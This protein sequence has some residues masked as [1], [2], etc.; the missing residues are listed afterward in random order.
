MTY[1]QTTDLH[2]IIDRIYD[3]A[4]S[5]EKWV[6]L[7][8]ALGEHI[9]IQQFESHIQYKPSTLVITDK[10]TNTE[11]QHF[12]QAQDSDLT[13]RQTLL[14]TSDL[15]EINL[16]LGKHFMRALKITQSLVNSEQQ[17]ELIVNFLDKLP[18]AV[19]I[20]D[21]QL[22]VFQS[23]VHA[24]AYIHETSV[25]KFQNNQLSLRSSRDQEKLCKLTEALSNVETSLINQLPLVADDPESEDKQIIIIGTPIKI[26]SLAS[27]HMVALFVSNRSSHPLP[28]PEVLSELYKLSDKE[29]EI[30]RLL[31]QGYSINEISELTTVSKHTVRNQ[32]KSIFSKTDTSRQ[33]ELVSLVLTGPG[34][35]TYDNRTSIGNIQSLNTLA[36]AGSL[37]KFQI[38]NRRTISWQE[39]GDPYG[40]AVIYGHS[41][42]GSSY[43]ISFD[44]DKILKQKGIRLIAPDRPGRCYS[45]A[46]DD[47][48]LSSLSHDLDKLLDH[49]KISECQYLGFE[50]GALF[51]AA[52][53]ALNKNRLKTLVLVSTGIIPDS[54]QEWKQMSSFFRMN[55][56]CAIHFPKVH[57]LF[58]NMMVHGIKEN[59]QRFLKTLAKQFSESEKSFTFPEQYIHGLSAAITNT[60]A[61]AAM[62][63]IEC[64]MPPGPWDF[65]MSEIECNIEQW[66]GVEDSFVP[67]ISAQ[68]LA[69][70]CPDQAQQHFIEG[71]GRF[72]FYTQFEK[73]IDSLLAYNH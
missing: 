40:Q 34:S 7:L 21:Q 43:E 16:V 10:E 6:D 55:L 73:I 68:R 12:L 44:Q 57:R 62:L 32:V 22:N 4:I 31:L 72:I 42:L 52:Y 46:D 18:V 8:H 65:E 48:S 13:S 41:S 26:A 17:N 15:N 59:P 71:E 39:Y 3:A 60:S 19:F 38:D 5:P 11:R 28:T 54:T 47:M 35:L 23:N 29:A 37:F 56:K 67:V 1:T 58:T 66:H 53:S 2:E 24:S 63:T 45:S 70:A 69:N 50:M 30:T 27:Q 51:G 64:Q 9:D 33:A 25:L 20:V 49:L 14:S 61:L 36:N